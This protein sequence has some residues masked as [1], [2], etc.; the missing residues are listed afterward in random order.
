M[1]HESVCARSAGA[2]PGWGSMPTQGADMN[3]VQAKSMTKSSS[4]KDVASDSVRPLIL[5][6]SPC[7]SVVTRVQ[8]YVA[9]KN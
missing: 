8:H 2:A 7:E 9:M 1:L 4:K 6:G 5:L 3:G